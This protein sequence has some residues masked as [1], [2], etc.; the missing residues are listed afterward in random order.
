MKNYVCGPCGYVYNPELGDQD[1]G[2]APEQ[3]LKTF[4][5]IGYVQSADL[6]KMYLKK[7]NSFSY[8]IYSTIHPEQKREAATLLHIKQSLFLFTFL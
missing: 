1:S 4:Q 3:H 5:T 2:I 6:I 7:N 8:N